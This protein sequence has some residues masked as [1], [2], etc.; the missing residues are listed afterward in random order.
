[1]AHRWIQ[2]C[3]QQLGKLIELA[4]VYSGFLMKSVNPLGKPVETD[5]LFTFDGWRDAVVYNDHHPRLARRLRGWLPSFSNISILQSI[6]D[7][8]IAVIDIT[9]RARSR[10]RHLR[11]LH[12]VESERMT[13]FQ[14]ILKAE[15][16]HFKRRLYSRY[17]SDMCLP[18][19]RGRLTDVMYRLQEVAIEK[20]AELHDSHVATKQRLE[21]IEQLLLRLQ[22][23]VGTLD[24]GDSGLAD[25]QTADV[26]GAA[27]H[28]TCYGHPLRSAT[29]LSVHNGAHTI[30]GAHADSSR[31]TQSE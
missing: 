28:E 4:Q 17:G 3:V 31:S 19:L 1:M 12:E 5:R 29:G 7:G 18:V 6:I 22:D 10:A 21:S 30:A 26:S 11:M 13:K 23:N 9:C 16:K 8:C 24:Q 2:T 27:Q 14:A 20:L 25:I 15:A